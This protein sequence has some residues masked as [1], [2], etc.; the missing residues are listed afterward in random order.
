M[1]HTPTRD[2]TL[3]V[4]EGLA[5]Y[6]AQQTNGEFTRPGVEIN[7]VLRNTEGK[8]SDSAVS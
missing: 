1:N 2:E 4:Q 6:N 7:L 5:D 8:V 3:A